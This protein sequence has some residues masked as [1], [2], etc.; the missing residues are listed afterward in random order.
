MT[1]LQAFG[2]RETVA[3]MIVGVIG[4]LI[5][6]LQPQL[7]GALAATGRIGTGAIGLLATAEL[8][9]MGIAAGGAGL[10]F[11]GDRLRAIAV[12]GLAISAACDLLT[13]LGGT[14][15]I[16]GL[17][18]VAGLAEGVLI[19]LAIGFIIRSGN[20]ERWSGLYLGIQTAAQFALASLIGLFVLGRTGATGFEWL[21]LVTVAGLLALPLLPR[22]YEALEHDE[23]ARDAIPPRG[24]IA[25]G[26]IV[27]YLAA[28]V[29]VWVYIEP[30]GLRRALDAHNVHIVA[31]LALG[32]QVIG[33]LAAA[34][35]AERLPAP[36]I[37]IAC[38]GLSLALLALLALTASPAVFI[39][40]AAAFGFLWLFVMPFQIPLVIAADPSRRAAVMIGG[41][42]LVGSSLGP[43]AAGMLVEGDDVSP[44]PLLGMACAITGVILL[45]GAGWRRA[46]P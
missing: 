39:A 25:L 19:W 22:S 16:F 41:A 3:V 27:F 46:V 26:G 23:A 36:G 43:F 11:K 10:L 13:P 40:A 12:M 15:A 44:V 24:W 28:V 8:L 21:A 33:A 18:I 4:V 35:L 32:C 30:L 17:R 1:P 37:V 34:W 2:R 20:P 42:Q 31:P 6:G 7:L 14:A 29:A 45:L 9:A 38:A 5:P